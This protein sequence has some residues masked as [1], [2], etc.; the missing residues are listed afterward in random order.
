RSQK[1]KQNYRNSR[2]ILQAAYAVLQEN[3][4]I[5]KIHTDDLEIIEPE[6]ANFSTPKPLLLNTGTLEEE[7]G[8]ALSYLEKHQRK[9]EKACIAFGGLS[10]HQVRAMGEELNI[11]VLDSV[12]NID[13]ANLFLS[14]LDQTK[15][16]EFDLMM[17][18]NCTDGNM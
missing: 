3:V 5:D 14:D 11:T 15:G 9:D 17:V 16:F 18:L 6:Y 1:I 4:N 8:Y 7:L 2:E 12:T 10:L 13:D